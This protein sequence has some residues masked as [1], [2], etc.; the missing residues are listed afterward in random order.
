MSEKIEI[1][2][3]SE[4]NLEDE[5]FDSLREDYENFD[6]WY[7]KKESSF[8]D[9]FVQCNNGKIQAFLYLKI[10]SDTDVDI[11]I[12]PPLKTGKKLKIGTFKINAHNT[13]LGERFIKL[14]VDRAIE[15]SVDYIYVTIF[16]KGLQKPLINLLVK[17]GFIVS[18]TKGKEQ[19]LIKD[20]RSKQGDLYEM[21]PLIDKKEKRKF[22]LAI[23]P[24]YHTKLFPDS[25]LKNEIL[26]KD[27]IIKD[28][29][30]TNSISKTYV[31]FMRDTEQLIPGDIIVIYRTN[32]GEGPAYFRSV[33]TS[34]CQVEEVKK[35]RDFND[36]NEFIHYTNRY[37]VFDEEEL[38]LWYKK[39]CVVIK[40]LYNATLKKRLTRKALIENVGLNPSVYW[41][42]FRLSDDEFEEICQ[43]GNIN[44]NI[45]IK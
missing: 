35:K 16:N 40:M 4:L 29:S 6:T 30:Y 3:F 32:D 22:V 43:L 20:M 13:K 37:S 45:F 34:V 41:G 19:V 21:Y 26:Q 9:V 5:F 12:L 31:C 33:V 38:S 24:K 42:F 23:Y 25:I 7:K 44:D 27:D 10:E 1:K 14:I 15:E 11:E 2:K 28:V 17:Y 8:E 18:G 36:E 39:E